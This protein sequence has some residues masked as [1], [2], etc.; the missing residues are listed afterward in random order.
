MDE[1][2]TRD[3]TNI[4][5]ESIPMRNKGKYVTEGKKGKDHDKTDLICFKQKPVA[6]KF[7]Q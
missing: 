2:S 3:S 4:H 7:L 6:Q 5:F 1:N